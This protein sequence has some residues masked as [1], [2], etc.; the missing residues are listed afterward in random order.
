MEPL[1]SGQTKTAPKDPLM[2]WELPTYD[3]WLDSV[4]KHDAL[5]V[6]CSLLE[7]SMCFQ[8]NLSFASRPF[9]KAAVSTEV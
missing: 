6:G 7:L 2:L 8:A 1:M 4:T 9:A 3:K 5:F